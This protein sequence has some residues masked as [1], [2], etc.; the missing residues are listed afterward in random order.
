MRVFTTD[1][2]D[3]NLYRIKGRRRFE[4]QDLTPKRQGVSPEAHPLFSAAEARPDGGP[5][6][7][8]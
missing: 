2:R 8:G 7:G 4:I 3:F 6:G 1:R 5:R